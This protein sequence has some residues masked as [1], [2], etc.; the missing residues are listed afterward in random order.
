MYTGKDRRI[1]LDD[2]MYSS[3]CKE[4]FVSINADIQLLKTEE[5]LPM[6]KDVADIKEKVFNGMSSMPR[7]MNWMIGLFVTVLIGIGGLVWTGA[8][9]QGRL[10]AM[11]LMHMGTTAQEIRDV[12]LEAE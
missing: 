7:K 9:D 4:R 6:R 8:R 3:I 2:N 11:I 5:I 12:I 1:N 10:E